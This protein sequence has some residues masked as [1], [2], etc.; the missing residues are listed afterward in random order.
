M[1]H[2]VH[3][4]FNINSDS[5]INFQELVHLRASCTNLGIHISTSTTRTN[6]AA[7]TRDRDGELKI[8]LWEKNN[9]DDEEKE[10]SGRTAK[11]DSTVSKVV[12]IVN[13]F[14]NSDKTMDR[15]ITDTKVLHHH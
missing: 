1:N 10:E 11:I 7:D 15:L 9:K 12:D 14:K 4:Y 5:F 6:A 13:H 8:F 3:I 2:T